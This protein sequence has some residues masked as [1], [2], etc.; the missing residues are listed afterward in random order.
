MLGTMTKPHVLLA[1]GSVLTVVLL[2]GCA[3]VTNHESSEDA[4]YSKHLEQVF[5]QQTTCWNAWYELLDSWRDR[6]GGLQ[7]SML[8]TRTQIANDNTSVF[9]NLVKD[10][11]SRQSSSN[12][13]PEFGSWPVSDDAYRLVIFSIKSEG[14]VPSECEAPIWLDAWFWDDLRS[15]DGDPRKIRRLS[16]MPKDVNGEDPHTATNWISYWLF[17]RRD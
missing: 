6:G 12:Q 15:V 14:F 10:S 13:V 11:W 17:V 16:D 8:A 7:D 9:A 4:D 1:F 2:C 5:A 3:S